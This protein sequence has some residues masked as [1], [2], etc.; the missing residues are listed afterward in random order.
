MKTGP[1]LTFKAGCAAFAEED[2]DSMRLKFKFTVADVTYVFHYPD[3]KQ[4]PT[5]ETFYI[6]RCVKEPVFLHVQMSMFRANV[7]ESILSLASFFSE[8]EIDCTFNDI[9]LISELGPL[10]SF[11]SSAESITLYDE[12]CKVL[13]FFKSDLKNDASECFSELFTQLNMFI[14]DKLSVI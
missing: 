11:D 13:R 14:Q 4:Q 5:L 1:F 2:K 3:H 9:V 12:G 8:V 6:E 10:I 7:T